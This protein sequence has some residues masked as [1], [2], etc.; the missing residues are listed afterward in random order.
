M[1]I[2]V[3]VLLFALL[4]VDPAQ[5]WGPRPGTLSN[6]VKKVVA[7]T[8]GAALLVGVGPV[9]PALAGNSRLVAEIPTS[10]F[11]F[12]DKLK[13]EA[14]ADPN[15]PGVTLFLGDFERPLTEKL[16]GD[17][18]D[19][20]T[21]STLSCVQTGPI[22]D[23]QIASL[24]SGSEGE[25]IF[26]ESKNLLFKSVKVRRVKDKTSGA[27]VYSSFSSRGDKSNDKN[28]NRFSSSLCVLMPKA[29]ASS[30]EQ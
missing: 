7:T 6:S 9:S 27:L 8:V 18:F 16:S 28:K 2:F 19:D 26:S 3:G 17:F 24:S 10:G 11:V 23:K 13:V 21:S 5:A 4:L 15:V 14:F 22:T 1:S 25:E 29:Q 20:P 12:K 30:L